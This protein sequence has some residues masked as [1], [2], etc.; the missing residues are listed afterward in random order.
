V[1]GVGTGSV[2]IDH[3]YGDGTI[4]GVRIFY[5]GQAHATPTVAIGMGSSHAR[6]PGFTFTEGVVRD[7]VIADTTGR[8]KRAVIGM[9]YSQRDATSRRFRFS[10]I[11][12]NGASEYLLLPGALGTYGPAAINLERISVNLT[13][14]VLA[15]E[16][17]TVSLSLRARSLTNRAARTVP[18][19]TNYDGSPAHPSMRVRFDRD[20]S[21][22]GLGD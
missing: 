15:T 13:R 21:V 12:D 22:R 1:S 10:D 9:Q 2:D 8:T 6:L 14:G 7:V 3:Q 20:S 17:L 4:E 18:V 19:R 5:S 16:D 11:T